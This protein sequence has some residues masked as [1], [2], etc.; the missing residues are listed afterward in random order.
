MSAESRS[1]GEGYASVFVL[2]SAT[3]KVQRF[4]DVFISVY[5]LMIFAYILSSWIRIGYSPTLARIQRFLHDTCEPYLGLF[6]RFIPPIGPLD[7]SPI[8]GIVVLT[9]IDRLVAQ[10]L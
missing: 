4:I 6:R 2:S 9:V 10:A 5:I 1:V 3:E 7:L 8:V